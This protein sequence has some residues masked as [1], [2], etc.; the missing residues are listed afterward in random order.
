MRSSPDVGLGVVPALFQSLGRHVVRCA[1]EGAGQLSGANQE[2]RY[3]EITQFYQ[4]PLQEYIPG[5]TQ[6]VDKPSEV[7][8]IYIYLG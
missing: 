8:C 6:T 4:V 7:S 5:H 3:P 2:T 1:S